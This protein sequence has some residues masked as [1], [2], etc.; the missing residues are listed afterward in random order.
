M[1]EI[2]PNSS[3]E[4]GN[5]QITVSPSP[6]KQN[7]G[8]IHHFFTFNNYHSSD[9]SFMETQ[10]KE[11]CYMYAFQE[12]MGLSGTRHLQGV[13]SCKKKMRDTAFKLPKAIHWEKLKSNA[14][15]A[16]EYCTKEDTRCGKVFVMNY[17]I[18]YRF[19]L[20]KSIFYEWEKEI[21]RIIT[22]EANCRD[23]H[24]FW[25]EGGGV[26]KSTFVKHLV[27]N[28]KAVFL[29]KGRY[30]DIVNVIYK[31]DMVSTRLVLIDLP[32][33]NGNNVSYSA[34]EAIKNGLIC[35][36]KFETGFVAFP[37][38]HV[39]VFANEEPKDMGFTDNRCI[40]TQIDE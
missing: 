30:S 32:R 14:K 38:P 18:P 24:W 6:P 7:S 12:E 19:K 11:Y 3:G 33:N 35:N 40:V 39:I 37:P 15:Q 16:Y 13:C 17:K 31:T 4:T 34:I 22:E 2:V 26:G 27:M 5:T 25:S 20:D 36:T 10:F 9:I 1:S 21:Y 28:E 29:S 8:R 23:V